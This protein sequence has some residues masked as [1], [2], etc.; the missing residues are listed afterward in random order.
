MLDYDKVK[1]EARFDGY[2]AIIT[3][4]TSMSDSKIIDTYRGLW[5][6]EDTF[7]VTKSI[8][9]TRPV[10]VYRKDH[11]DGH[12]LVCYIALLLLRLIEYRLGWKY[13]AERIV[14]TMRE[15]TCVRLDDNHYLFHYADEVTDAINAEFQ[16]DFGRRVMALGDIRKSLSETK[17]RP[18]GGQEFSF[19]VSKY[20]RHRTNNSECKTNID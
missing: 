17:K 7:K 2:Y 12:F 13:S 20:K 9:H 15:A 18:D 5:Q 3:S 16:T 19:P 14:E 10:F 11:I 1:D 4:E 6:I 8:L